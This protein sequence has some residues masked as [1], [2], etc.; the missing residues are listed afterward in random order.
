[1]SVLAARYLAEISPTKAAVETEKYI[2]G[3]FIKT[4]GMARKPIA[5]VSTED[6][7]S[8]R[9][10]RLKE[11]YH[12][13]D[14]TEDGKKEPIKPSTVR[15]ELNILQHI[16]EIARTE[17]GY[18]DLRNPFRGLRIKQSDVPRARRLKDGELGILLT[19]AMRDCKGH[20]KRYAPLAIMLAV[21]TGM[22]LQE[23]FNLTWGDVSILPADKDKPPFR[24]IIIRKSK[25]G[26]SRTIVMDASSPD[27]SAH[28]GG[29]GLRY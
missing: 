27:Y 26:K 25:T 3:R 4:S 9:N 29:C 6:G 16:F 7:A 17:W 21:N 19:S 18:S 14:G 23:I 5:H 24:R 8:Y 2:I 15:R 12:R 20:N 1:M 22:R 10:E 28:V 13:K 11:T